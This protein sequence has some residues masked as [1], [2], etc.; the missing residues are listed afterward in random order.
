MIEGLPLVA[1]NKAFDEDCL[2]KCYHHY[3]LSYPNYD[4]YCTLRDSRKAFPELEHY[5]LNIVSEHVGFVLHDHHHAL[6]DAEPC[7]YIAMKL[8]C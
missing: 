3:K 7:A 1:H 6:A 2:Q 5:N 8:Y 4:F